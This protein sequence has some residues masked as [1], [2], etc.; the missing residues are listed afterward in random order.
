[1]KV[2]YGR[3]RCNDGDDASGNHSSS[4][5]PM[6]LSVWQ[7]QSTGFTYSFQRSWSSEMTSLVINTFQNL[8]N[9]ENFPCLFPENNLSSNLNLQYLK[10]WACEA[11]LIFTLS[12]CFW[13]STCDPASVI[14]R[15][16]TKFQFRGDC[17][18]QQ[19]TIF[20]FRTAV[21]EDKQ[22][23][24][25]PS[26]DGRSLRVLAGSSIRLHCGSGSVSW[27]FQRAVQHRNGV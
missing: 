6:H 19:E 10:T 23:D 27:A 5:I 13:C 24:I 16:M 25:A 15:C 22:M 11:Y 7:I 4:H 18:E 26:M 9:F 17:T 21:A 8:C 14:Y 3:H 2:T 12:F 20:S 1:M